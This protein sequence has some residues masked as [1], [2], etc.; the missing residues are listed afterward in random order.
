VNIVSKRVLEVV[1][2]ATV[3]GTDEQDFLQAAEKANN[4]L[5][6][7]PGFIRRSVAKAEDG[8]WTDLVEWIMPI[9][10][11]ERRRSSTR[12][13]RLSHSAL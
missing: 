11:L 12:C 2:F 3:A 5:Q 8:T 4:A 7:L 1:T 13:P 9:V 6:S 10:R